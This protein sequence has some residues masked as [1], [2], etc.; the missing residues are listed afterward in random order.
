MVNS[1]KH[2]ISEIE[3]HLGEQV[4]DTNSVGGG[5]IANS[6]KITTESGKVY[7]VKSGFA[8]KMFQ[9]E[10]SGLQEL[11]KPK[12]IRVP[13]VIIVND[14]YLLLEFV[15]TG[16]KKRD[17][18]E[19]FG[20]RFADMHRF[21]GESFGFYEDN[22]IG[23]TPQLNIPLGNGSKNWDEFYF[24]NRLLFQY[25][26]S[27]ENGYST[28]KLRKGFKLL[29]NKISG[30]LKGSE[31]DPSLLHGD[32]W[33]GNYMCDKNGDAVIIDPAVYYGHREADLAMTKLF[34]GFS[35]GF[36]KAY[37]ESWPLL[38]GHKYRE[39][40]YLLYHVMNHLNLFGYGYLS[41]AESLL[42][43]YLK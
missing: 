43:Y 20:R 36:Y 16:V 25:R 28:E 32:L 40:I 18:F 6:R 38:P 3:Q 29:E 30:I 23:A 21:S 13:E 9:N 7:F 1:D 34:G 2:I 39:N 41:Q 33:S 5:C 4:V 15:A 35:S 8:G 27:E 10:A 42:W 17:F 24:Q 22:F 31:E 11:S 14:D 12:A 37:N 19:D 26:L